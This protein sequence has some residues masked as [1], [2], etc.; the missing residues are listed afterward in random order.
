MNPEQVRLDAD[1]HERIFR[2]RIVPELLRDAATDLD[3]PVVVLLG[4]QPGV[5]KSSF[6]VALRQTLGDRGGVLDFGTDLMRPYHP[7]FAGVGSLDERTRTDL[8][9]NGI[10]KDAVGW[11]DKAV[12]YGIRRRS[13]VILDSNLAVPDRARDLIQQFTS[14]GYRAEVVFIAGPQA[15]SRLGVLTRYQAQV[16]E[17]GWGFYVPTHIQDSNYTNVLET[18]GMI[19]TERNADAVTVFRR[20]GG[21][22]LDSNHRLT[23]GRWAFPPATRV[24]IETERHRSWRP[25]ESDWFVK[26]A[27]DLAGR[28]SP[29]YLGD[30]RDTLGLAQPLLDPRNTAKIT[31]LVNK[32]R[33]LRA[34]SAY[35][36]AFPAGPILSGAG[37]S[38]P[39]P[40]PRSSG[41]PPPR[42]GPGR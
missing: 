41:P 30:L 35:S 31:D 14:A 25:A 23:N 21:D 1:H 18:A 26:T 34:T 6:K 36:A 12:A 17:A 9:Q 20:G 28:L 8:L 33:P 32:I 15:L 37:S 19:E 40:P 42:L 4:G 29:H 22:P 13:N 39:Q 7:A 38:P 10:G 16:E 5:G 11:T 2:E 27:T 3:A 24:S